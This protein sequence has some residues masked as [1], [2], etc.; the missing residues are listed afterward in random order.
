V[1]VSS[2]DPLWSR[3]NPTYAKHRDHSNEG[4]H[5]SRQNNQIRDPGVPAGLI[6]DVRHGVR[7]ERYGESKS[8]NKGGFHIGDKLALYPRCFKNAATGYGQK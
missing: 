8:P 1:S 2:C 3:Q 4:V 6:H 5:L 7:N